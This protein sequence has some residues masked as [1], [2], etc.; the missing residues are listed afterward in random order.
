[1]K[2]LS[3]AVPCYNSAAYMQDTIDSLLK[4]GDRV[5]IIIVDD[6]S[7]KDNTLEIAKQNEAA[8]PNI[9]R[10]IHQE[11]GGHGEAVN[12]GLKN[13][14][15]RYFKVVDSDDHLD[16]EAYMK[17]LDKLES[18]F[19][20]DETELDAFICNYVYDKVGESSSHQKVIAYRNVLPQGKVFSWEDVGSFRLG[21]YILMHSVIYRTEMLRECGLELPKHTFYVDNIYV[22][23]PLPY[24][25][26][27]YYMDVNLYMYYIGRADQSVNEQIMIGRIDQQLRVNKLLI[28]YYDLAKIQPDKLANYLRSYLNIML[29]VSSILAI[30]SGTEENLKKRD[31]LWQ[32]LKSVN[33]EEYERQ[34]KSLFGIAM[35]FNSKPGLTFTSF[36]YKIA[37]KI[38][39]FN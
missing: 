4:G 38:Y 24:I 28:D 7:T 9:V 21:Q 13:A 39:G 26:R 2:I 32:Y 8:H 36:C 3:I 31:E 27:M 30:R 11:N 5:E 34:R 6:G 1:M 17:V 29:A 19:N 25:K 15:G 33:A 20:T 18:E 35:N 37:Q 14:S 12:T 16:T 10:V 23:Y 22:Y